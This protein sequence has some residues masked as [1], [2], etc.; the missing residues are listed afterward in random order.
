MASV[1]Y[2]NAKAFLVASSIAVST[3]Q[4]IKYLRRKHYLSTNASRKALHICIGPLFLS[5]W[6]LFNYNHSARYFAAAIPCCIVSQFVM[7]GSGILKDEDTVRIMSRSGDPSE[8]LKGPILYGLV[9]ISSTILY[10][11]SLIG[12]VALSV[13]C[14]GDGFAALI[15]SKYP[16]RKLPWNR[17]KSVGGSLA[18]VAFS[19]PLSIWFYFYFHRFGWIDN[20]LSFNEFTQTLVPVILTATFVESLP[21]PDIDNLTVFGSVIA[22]YKYFG[23]H[24]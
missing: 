2:A 15:G 17:K 7:I 11:R 10:W 12:A 8:I 4:F 5:T 20:K 21:I 6:P 18:F 24:S 23:K 3:V 13:L 14:A 16:I 22:A 19:M 9:F 1:N